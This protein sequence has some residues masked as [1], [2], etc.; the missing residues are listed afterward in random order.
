MQGESGRR[1]NRQNGQAFVAFGYKHQISNS[2]YAV[3]GAPCIDRAD[4]D[5]VNRVVLQQFLSSW[6][7]QPECVEGAD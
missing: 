3:G 7:M 1:P 6:G 5:E 4:G 2:G